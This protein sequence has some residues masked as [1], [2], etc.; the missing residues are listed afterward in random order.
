M[1]R[2]A[3]SC[4][5]SCTALATLARMERYSRS[6]LT[7]YWR[8]TPAPRREEKIWHD[9]TAHHNTRHHATTQ[10]NTTQFNTTQHNTA[11][12][13]TTQHNTTQHNQHT[14]TN[15][16]QHNVT[17]HHKTQHNGTQHNTTQHNATQRTVS[18][19]RV[20]WCVLR[21]RT[22]KDRSEERINQDNVWH[23]LIFYPD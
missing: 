22:S 16:T 23:F 2:F 17:Y 4:P 1:F 10:H 20:L 12:H 7:H 13:N 9:T 3:L 21:Y 8:S 11:Q 14:T 6:L 15:I 19:H 18:Q 5:V